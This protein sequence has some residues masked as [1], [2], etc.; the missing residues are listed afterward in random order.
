VITKLER[1]KAEAGLNPN[2]DWK[3]V[4]ERVRRFYEE[5]N[6]RRQV[7]VRLAGRKPVG[8]VEGP[9]TLNNEPHIGHVRGRIMKDLWYRYSTLLGERVVFR[10]GWDTQGLPVEL[11]AEKELGLTGSKWENL[12]QVGVEKLVEA[13]KS[14][15][16]KYKIAWQEADRLLGLMLDQEKAYMTYR[17]EYIEREWKYL[18]TAWRDGLLGEGYKVVPYCPS[19][20][21]ALSHAEVAEGGYEQLEDPSLYYKVKAEDGTWLVV[22]TTMP[23]TVVTDELIGVK[24]DAQYEYVEVKGETWVVGSERKEQ[25]SKE[26]GVEFGAVV[27][28]VKGRELEGI[29]YTHPLLDEIGGLRK[30]AWGTGIHRVVA[31]EFV[32]TTTGTGLVHISPANGEED[33]EVARRRGISVFA[34]FDDQARFTEEAGEFAGLF[35]RDADRLVSSKLAEKGALVHEGR[36]VHDY[37][38]CWRS[39]HRLVWLMRR[40]YFYWVDRLRE[41]LVKAAERVEYFFESPRNRF[42]EFIKESPPWCI[43]RE[44]VWGAPL[45][46][47]VC[48][49]CG[50]KMAVFSRNEII[51][52]AVEL[53]DGPGFELHKPW[54]DRVVLKCTKCG[55]KA[56]REQFVLDTW[57]NSGSAPYASFTDREYMSLVPVRFLTEGIDQTRGWA[58]TLLVLNV[59][60]TGR[61][62]APYRSFLFQGHVLDEKGRKMSKS[63]GNVVRGLELLRNSSVDLSRFYMMWKSSPADSL[64]FD[65]QEMKSRPYQV[66]NTL[67]HEHVYLLQNGELDGYDPERHTLAWARG[68]RLLKQPDMWALSKLADAERKVVEAYSCGRYNEA[69]R[70]IEDVVIS[71]VSQNYVRMVRSELWEDSPRSRKRRLAI[72]AVL[73]HTLRRLDTLL[74]PVCPFLTEYL[75]QEVFT[76]RSRWKRSILVAGMGRETGRVR[77]RVADSVDMA[78]RV[79]EACNSARMKAKLKRRWP[80]RSMTVL[81]GRDQKRYA[82]GSSK[83]SASLCNV[84]LVRVTTSAGSFPASFELVPNGAKLGAVF[85]ERTGELLSSLKTVGGEAALRRW[86]SQKPF[87]VATGSGTVEVPVSCFELKVTP[88][89]GFEVAEKQGVFVAIETRR[90]DALVAEGLLRDIARRLQALRKRRGFSPTA[91]LHRAAVAGLE[92]EEVEL[93]R[94]LRKRLAYLVRVREAEVSVE[95]GEGK[96]EED[97]LD[98]RKIFVDVS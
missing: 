10:A 8:Y 45:P 53:P 57:H 40:E 27:K 94:P 22:W 76:G 18:E 73:G 36:I 13:C 34:P 66:L 29:R 17:D 6:V 39:G 91:L 55:G 24:P 67:Y 1:E 25:L 87:T 62:L 72:F 95:R 58:Y 81:V 16:S 30:L 44:R 54:I 19:C 78:L 98:G 23:F 70:A 43:T 60:K 74:H 68:R 7:E 21:T 37:P 32:D 64:T 59:I 12:K 2:Y 47:W 51:R 80:L 14:L 56:Y 9:P 96:W 97:E 85:R 52:L 11:Q 82:V 61:P 4:E 92:K 38:V 5:K 46:I 71:V 93:L 41:K 48:S 83:L 89:E 26:I 31:E 33:F 75:Y 50:E 90:D 20:Q 84:K 3:E 88:R 49:V 86:L 35:V 65:A 15:V 69:C 42:I 77:G 63:L 28:R 79:E